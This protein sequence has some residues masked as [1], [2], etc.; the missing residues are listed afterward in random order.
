M[1]LA[2]RQVGQEPG[3]FAAE[4][5]ADL[6][7]VVAIPRDMEQHDVRKRAAGGDPD[8]RLESYTKVNLRIGIS[9][10]SWELMAYGRNIFDEEAA[11]QSFDTPVLAGSHSVYIDEGKVF[12][13]R[14]KYSF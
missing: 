4:E 6:P 13:L 9:G 7:R 12:G 2:D 14:G 11:V 5:R 3:G 1:L 8:D 10:E